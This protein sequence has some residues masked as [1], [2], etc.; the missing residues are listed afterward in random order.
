MIIFVKIHQSLKQYF[1][2]RSGISSS[3]SMEYNHRKHKQ[4]EGS[5]SLSEAL[6]KAF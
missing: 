1:I 4:S 3:K 6:D 2:A 5:S